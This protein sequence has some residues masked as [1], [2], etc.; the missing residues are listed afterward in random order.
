MCSWKGVV[1]LTFVDLAAVDFWQGAHRDWRQE[2]D[3]E[4]G[5]A[6]GNGRKGWGQA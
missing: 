6:I 5:G 1:V 4:E 3:S 2:W